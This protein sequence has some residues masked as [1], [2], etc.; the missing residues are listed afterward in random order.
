MSRELLQRVH[1]F[2]CEFS[3]DTVE[4]QE[5]DTLL[6]LIAGELAKPEPTRFDKDMDGSMEPDENGPWVRYKDV[7]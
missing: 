3:G 4:M 7:T 2:L 1:T 6:E 5:A